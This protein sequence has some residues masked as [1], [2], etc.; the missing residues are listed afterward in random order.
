MSK[1]SI[2]RKSP[3]RNYSARTLKLLFAMSGNQCAHPDCSNHLIEPATEQS[4]SLVTAHI[5]HI[6]ALNS[7]GPRGKLGLTQNELNSHENLILLCRNHHAVVDGQHD[8]YPAH[9]LKDWKRKHE[10]KT[11]SILPTGTVRTQPDIFIN[12]YFPKE[13]VDK[14][15]EDE[16]DRLRKIRFFQEFD[17]LTSSLSLSRRLVDRELSGGSDHIRS[18]ALAWCVRVLCRGTELDE[19]NSLL[20]L[21]QEL[22]IS[23]EIAIAR[24]FLL[25]QQ[26]NKAGALQILAKVNTP[27]ARSAA[28]MIVA[29][30]DGADAAIQWLA[31]TEFGAIDLDSDGKSFLLTQQLELAFWDLASETLDTVSTLDY[32]STPV[33]HHLAALT[34]LLT[35]VPSDF[36]QVVLKQ[37]PFHALGFPLASHALA[38]EARREAHECFRN[39]YE[40]AQQ[41]GCLRA[42]KIADE[43]TLWLE[44]KDPALSTFGRTRL[45]AKLHDPS[46]ALAVVHLGLQCAIKLDLDIVERNIDREIARNGT[47]TL[48][49]AL[50][51]FALV[52][53]QSTAR[54]AADYLL[55]HREQLSKHIDKKALLFR[56]IELFARAGMVETATEYLDSLVEQEIP[57][58]EQSRL[59]LI[60]AEAKGNDPVEQRKQQ[61]RTTGQLGDLINLVEE[62]EARQHWAQ[63]YEFGKLLFEETH[64]LRDAERLV[65]AL[66]NTRRAD[67]IVEF[68]DA[69]SDILSQSNFLQMSYAWALYNEGALNRARS[70]LQ[71]IQASSNSPNFRALQVNLAVTSGDWNSLS[72]FISNEY[73]QRD[74][75]TAEELITAAQIAVSLGSSYARELVFQAVQEANDD[76]GILAT[77]YFLATSAGWEDQP[78]VFQWLQRASDLSEGDGPLQRLTLREVLNRNPEWE[79]HA[80]ETCNCSPDLGSRMT[81]S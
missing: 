54:D 60:I 10:A 77:A 46:S 68:L 71:K 12:S 26:D 32:E 64:A 24:A 52:F 78:N 59:R 63:M 40:A 56:Q 8:T 29:N 6:Y 4:D 14:K 67:T 79:E 57:A 53:E 1:N 50:A 49:A 43:Y 75:R 11:Q 73:Q 5:C 76:P 28:L 15:I 41:L 22:G 55:R 69:N 72:V 36:R 21:A 61:Y 34:K 2:K 3:N 65:T 44:L 25:S 13:L 17:G 39:A 7:A 31:A 19:A 81:N 33:L 16:I 48:D 20:Q 42:A 30:H 45:E 47:I 66:Q 70:T 74:D 9:L 38:M 23:A 27:S 80:S 37:V 62:V 18:R 51:R 58:H 35:T